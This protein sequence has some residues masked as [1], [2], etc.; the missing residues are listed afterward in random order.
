M[1][2]EDIK[3]AESKADA[4][5]EKLHRIRHSMAHVMAEAVLQMFPDGKVA[6][7]PAIEN[8]FYYDFDLPRSLKEEDLEDITLRMQE[9]IKKGISFERRVITRED[10]LERFADQP[11][12]VELISELPEGEEIS[13]YSQGDFTDLCR[14]P[15]VESTSKLNPQSFKLLS[16]AGAYWRGD[17]KRP[18]LQRIYGTAWTNPKDLRL[19]LQQLEE[20]EKRDHRKVGRELDLFSTHEEAGPGLVYWHPKGARIRV[21]IEDFWREEHRKNGYEF[22]FTPHVGK[23]WLWE[24]SGHLDFYAEGMYPEMIM[25][26]ANYYAKPMNC[27]FHIMIYK[28]NKHSYRE[29]PFR[30]AELGTVYRYE[31]SGTLHGL[32]RVRGFTQDDA[33]IFCTP[34][35]V[36]DEILEVLRF[37]LHMLRSFG[38]KDIQAYLS[39]MPEKAVGDPDQWKLAEESLRKAI[40]AEG[41]EYEVDE[42]GGAFYGPKIDLKIKDALGRSW[43][44]STVQF[45]FNEPERFNMTYTDKSGAEKRPYMVHRAL[46]GSLERFF[47][48]LI[49]HYS[50]AF[51]VWLAPTQIMVIPVAA[52]FEEYAD[53]VYRQLKEAGFRVDLDDSDDRL[54]AK[55]RNAQQDKIPY[56][57]ILGE[58]EAEAGGVSVRFRNGKQENGI[59]LND[60]IART[61]SVI[62][63]KKEL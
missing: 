34:E 57:L 25:D 29:L 6:I 16:I 63:D 33:H 42:G 50:G 41:L 8:G 45:D 37:S 22:L 2:K 54:N 40:E 62:S 13:I 58:K 9:I 15:H 61:N 49:E 28:T 60:F 19:Y 5:E 52:A 32:L 36:E 48:V 35:Q 18:M 51:P 47:G 46:L 24:T 14:G 31:K 39:T 44:L 12:K 7:G 59:P 43:Q 53:T 21:A 55:I 56:M 23:S 20:L 3:A 27:P 11:Y 10:A 4:K 17:E 1:S 26:K 30:W 38:F